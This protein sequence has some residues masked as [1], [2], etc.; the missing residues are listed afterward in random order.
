MPRFHAEAALLPEGW[1]ADVAIDV[2][3]RGFITAATPGAPA[4]DRQRLAGAVVP[5]MPNLHCHAFQRAM[6]GLAE[7]A[8]P[9][10]DNF[11]SWRDLMYRFVARLGPAEV[12]AIAAQLQVEL[13][14]QGYTA[15]AEF[16]YLHNDRD[17]I[18]YEA[19]TQLADAICAAAGASGIGLTLLPVA[20]RNGGFGGKPTGPAQA[21][22]VLDEERYAALVETLLRRHRGDAQIRVGVAPHSLRAIAPDALTRLVAMIGKLDAQAP[23][24]IHVAEQTREVEDCIAWSGA[25]P[26]AWL[27]DH[28]PVD[29][30]WCAVHATHMDD[31]ETA[32]LARSG[33]V[34]GL[35]PTTEA[36]L[37]DGLFSLAS[38][39]RAGGAL[40]IGSDSNV[41]TSPAEELRWLEYGARLTARARNLFA[42]EHGASTGGALLRAALAGG[43]QACGRPIGAIAKGL[44]ADL[45]VLDT[46]HPVLV[47][48]A[49]DDLIDGWIFSGNDTPV[50]DVIVGGEWVVRERH[51]PHE[52]QARADYARTVRRIIE[53]I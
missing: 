48:R 44:R 53:E 14:K 6:A 34:A 11:W 32:R 21:R 5:G 42:P 30:R 46:E 2:D 17:G 3:A 24:H 41:S 37:G 43:A 39:A 27:L 28:A 15:V 45:V 47:G 18:A 22:F 9:A 25:R 16:H 33:A 20:Y 19:P 40:G 7:R 4:A 31:S 23:I 8:G 29:A 10:G 51:H 13:L 38:Y 36:N 52:E 1:R 49:G 26:V 12:E 35:C 50:R